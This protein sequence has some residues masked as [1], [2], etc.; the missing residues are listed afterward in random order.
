M[1]SKARLHLIRCSGDIEPQARDRRRERGFQLTV[2]DGGRQAIVAERVDPWEA[3]FG[4]FGRALLV[5]EANYAAILAASLTTLELHVRT[6]T[7]Q[8]N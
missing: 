5:A 7:R 4:V 6:D 3:L 2:I 1:M 8:T